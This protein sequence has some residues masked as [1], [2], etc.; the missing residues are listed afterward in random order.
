MFFLSQKNTRRLRRVGILLK[1]FLWT[2]EAAMEPG[3]AFRLRQRNIPSFAGFAPI[4][5][6][7]R[8]PRC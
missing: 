1:S 5:I 6:V 8:P 3:I 7:D 2:M 4:R